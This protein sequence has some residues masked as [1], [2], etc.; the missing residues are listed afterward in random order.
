MRTEFWSIEIPAPPEQVFPY[1]WDNALIPRWVASH[2]AATYRFPAEPRMERTAVTSIQM[3]GGWHLMAECIKVDLNREVA[4]RFVQG[5]IKGTERWVLEPAGAGV[6]TM[7]KVLE[8]EIEGSF[9][10]F[11][12]SVYG[13]RAHSRVSVLELEALRDL[14][15]DTT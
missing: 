8:Y 6:T 2:N 12:W 7:R 3:R 10:R 15:A 4:H 13:R 11:I 9:H 1:L 5:P 14:V